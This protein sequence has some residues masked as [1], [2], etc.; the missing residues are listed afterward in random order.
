MNT[1]TIDFGIMTRPDGSR[2]RLTMEV[3]AS[4]RFSINAMQTPDDGTIVATGE[5]TDYV[6]GLSDAS[7]QHIATKAAG[8][9][10]WEA[11]FHRLASAVRLLSETC[12]YSPS[13]GFSVP[14]AEAWDYLEQCAH[15]YSSTEP[16]KPLHEP[17]IKKP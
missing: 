7:V 15:H 2:A 16:V 13:M 9:I 17:D 5:F 3:S 6:A 12:E 10:D 1:Q 11:R 4:G 14:T 8:E